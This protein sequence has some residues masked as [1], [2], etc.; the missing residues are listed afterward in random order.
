MIYSLSVP[1]LAL[2]M[3][4]VSCGWRTTTC[5]S[6]RS[7]VLRMYCWWTDVWSCSIIDHP[8]ET[9]LA[10]NKA[11][12]ILSTQQEPL[13]RGQERCISRTF[14]VSVIMPGWLCLR[15]SA[16]RGTLWELRAVGLGLGKSRIENY[17]CPLFFPP[18]WEGWG[19]TVETVLLCLTTPAS[20]LGKIS[21]PSNSIWKLLQKEE[22]TDS[23]VLIV[24]A[25][26][27]DY[28]WINSYIRMESYEQSFQVAEQL[29]NWAIFFGFWKQLPKPWS[30][31]SLVC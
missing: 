10:R 8:G 1:C 4:N 21:R 3:L 18:Q 14:L 23:V 29:A 28:V 11:G 26:F 25:A 22:A 7:Q 13:G 31:R 30:G 6:S 24:E 15:L 17:S 27:T 20:A 9:G 16:L 12:R 2:E 19:V 5:F